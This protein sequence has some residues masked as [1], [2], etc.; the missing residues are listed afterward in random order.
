MQA[1]LA[2][3]DEAEALARQRDGLVVLMHANPFLVRPIGADGYQEVRGRLRRLGKTM[4]GKVLL[5]HGDTHRFRDDEPLS[6]L[7]RVEVYGWPHIRWAKAR[8]ERT[9]ARLFEVELMPQ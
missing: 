3:L 6:G 2:W 4:P 8:I 7:R 9:G 1:V 5:V